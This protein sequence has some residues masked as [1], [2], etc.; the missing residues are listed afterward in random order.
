MGKVA[1]GTFLYGLSTKIQQTQNYS[2][3][4]SE[5]IQPNVHHQPHFNV[6]PIDFQFCDF[7][8]SMKLPKQNGIYISCF[9]K[10]HDFVNTMMNHEVQHQK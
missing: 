6:I 7:S 2:N 3:G 10:R 4:C 1:H 5:A 8:I 9:Q